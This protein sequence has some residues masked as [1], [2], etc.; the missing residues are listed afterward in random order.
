MLH[1]VAEYSKFMSKNIVTTMT[2]LKDV[3]TSDKI[4]SHC[5]YLQE[6]KAQLSTMQPLMLTC[7]SEKWKAQNGVPKVFFTSCV[8]YFDFN[9]K[10][11]SI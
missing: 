9:T 1:L 10:E 5:L 7:A 4:H 8:F 2:S 3:A 6:L 11:H